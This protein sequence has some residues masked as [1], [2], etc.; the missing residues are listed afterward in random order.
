MKEDAAVTWMDQRQNHMRPY[1][2]Q[3]QPA[4]TDD[5]TKTKCSLLPHPTDPAEVLALPNLDKTPGERRT[6]I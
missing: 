6:S 3:E 5:N 4:E 2:A 1:I